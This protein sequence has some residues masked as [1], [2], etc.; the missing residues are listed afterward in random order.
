MIWEKQ[1]STEVNGEISQRFVEFISQ[2]RL[3]KFP[4]GQGHWQL[5]NR[6]L[7]LFQPRPYRQPISP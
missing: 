6:L 3:H 7:E 1:L 4:Q 2:V 5:T